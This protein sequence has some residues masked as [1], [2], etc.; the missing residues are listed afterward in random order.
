MGSI[1]KRGQTYWVKYYR[2]G[3]AYRESAK[4]TKE[5][6][7]KRLLKKR[8]GEVAEGKIPGI[9][10]DR[11]RWDELA[12]D[13]LT[14][15]RQDGRKTVAW[16]ERRIKLHLA[17]F[18]GGLRATDITTPRIRE[19]VAKRLECTCAECK[20]RFSPQ[21]TC[22]ECGSGNLEPGAEN[23]TINRELAALKRMLNLGAEQTPPKVD[24]VPH[25]PML[26]ENNVR[27]GF[28]EHGDYLNLL[29]ALPEHLR[30]VVNFAYRTGWR[31][32][33]IL[34]LTWDRV[35]L[36]EGTVRLEA[37]ETKN[38]EARTV[39]L[40]SELMALLKERIGERRL[41]CPLVFHDNGKP[42]KDFR[43]AW[44]RACKESGI[45]G[46]LL[47]D[48]RRT[49]VRN[50]V[51]AGVPERVAMM[52]SGHKTRSVF[53]RYNVVSPEDLKQAAA[54]QQAYLEGLTGT[55]SGTI[56]LGD[57]SGSH[58]GQAQ[59]GEITGAWGGSRT[60]T[61]LCSKGF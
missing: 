55:I 41:G 61:E 10:F 43:G 56:G 46:K 15:Q 44:E 51:R 16:T 27:K 47:H 11:V 9:Y 2:N 28:L 5:G 26:R 32:G 42:I 8:E 29:E 4:S 36:K 13:Y 25:I 38:S 52:V 39:Y 18:F 14:E 22:P 54:R 30:P 34:G 17:P 35:D 12:E 20:E 7:A 23:G 31:R 48:F 24:R 21:D 57:V 59:V 1:Y 19:Y 53:D 6:A 60:R 40:D 49:A 33:E 37:G 3:K 50:M 45:P 58:K